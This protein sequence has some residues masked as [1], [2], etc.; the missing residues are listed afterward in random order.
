MSHEPPA[1]AR[2]PFGVR[3]LANRGITRYQF[4]QCNYHQ[5]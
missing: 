5:R 1:I 4:I 3:M 2:T